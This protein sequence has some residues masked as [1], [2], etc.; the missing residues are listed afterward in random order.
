MH[1][2][3]MNE[4]VREVVDPKAVLEE[5]RN[6]GWSAWLVLDPGCHPDALAQLYALESETKRRC[7]FLI[8]ALS[9]CTNSLPA[10]FP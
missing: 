4:V 9:T 2:S 1:E 10:S 7:F 3:Q 8:P 5:I 6:K